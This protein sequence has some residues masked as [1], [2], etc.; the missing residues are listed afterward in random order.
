[1]HAPTSFSPL[2]ENLH[3]TRKQEFLH[4]CYRKNHSTAET[5]SKGQRLLGEY[6][7]SDSSGL[8]VSTAKVIADTVRV[9]RSTV[10]RFAKE[11]GYGGFPDLKRN[12]R[13]DLRSR[14]RAATRMN[15]TIASIG[16][17]E[18]LENYPV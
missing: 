7:L 3:F 1:L 14:L 4:D 5:M 9:S 17:A 2:T 15:Q 6:L 13:K 11:L 18:L 16:K 10:I 8:V 12:L